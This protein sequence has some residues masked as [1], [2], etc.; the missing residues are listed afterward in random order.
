MRSFTYLLF[1]APLLAL[2]APTPGDD[3]HG[4]NHD[5]DG[6]RHGGDHGGDHHPK[7]SECYVQITSY[8]VPPPTPTPPATTSPTPTPPTPTSS[9]PP[10]TT[11]TKAYTVKASAPGKPIDGLQMEAGGLGFHL[12]GGT[13]SYCPTQVGQCP[14]GKE[15]VFLGGSI[16]VEVPGGQQQYT[17]LQGKIGYTQAHSAFMPTGALPG[18]FGYYKSPIEQYGHI[19]DTLFGSTGLM[20]C[21]DNSL[22]TPQYV[23]YAKVTN[24]VVPSGNVADCIDF[25]GLTTDY[26]GPLP[27]AWQ[28]T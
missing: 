3:H 1:A 22:G 21:P 28:Y 4:G 8:P 20:A 5:H 16:S 11:P 9:E 12:G 17:T 23:V 14:P 24:A 27:A 7:P 26:N 15:T 18:G 6:G 2:A 10:V 25:D 13:A 19:T